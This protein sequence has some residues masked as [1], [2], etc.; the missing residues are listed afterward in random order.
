MCLALSATTVAAIG[1][2]MKKIHR[3]DAAEIR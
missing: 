3:Q 1:T 2:L